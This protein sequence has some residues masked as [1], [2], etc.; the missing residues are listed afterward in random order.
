M[1]QDSKQGGAKLNKIKIDFVRG[2]GGICELTLSC[3]A[4]RGEK[5]NYIK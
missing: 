3:M 4:N 1:Q 5:L 2:L